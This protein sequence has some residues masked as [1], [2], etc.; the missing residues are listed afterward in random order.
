MQQIWKVMQAKPATL[1]DSKACYHNA[2]L[3][4]WASKWQPNLRLCGANKK[5][6]AKIREFYL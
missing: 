5:D 2:D 3:F 1:Y 4:A 6:Q